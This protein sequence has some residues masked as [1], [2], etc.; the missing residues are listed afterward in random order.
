MAEFVP[1]QYQSKEDF[2]KET[3]FVK[4]AVPL[5]SFII[6]Y[7][8]ITTATVVIVPFSFNLI[9]HVVCFLGYQCFVEFHPFASCQS[10]P[11]FA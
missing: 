4:K 6:V 2:N 3:A 5:L 9:G 1:N 10:N 8:D 7:S 11:I